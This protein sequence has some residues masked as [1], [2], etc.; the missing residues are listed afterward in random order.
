MGRVGAVLTPVQRMAKPGP[1]GEP[2]T[3]RLAPEGPHA[4]TER[5]SS[6]GVLLVRDRGGGQLFVVS[7]QDAPSGPQQRD[8]AAGFQGLGTLVD[9]HH[10]EVVVGQQ[11]EGA[12]GRSTWSKSE[13]S[14]STDSTGCVI[15]ATRAPASRLVHNRV[16]H[17]Y[18]VQHTRILE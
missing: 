12:V 4:G 7:S 6:R 17:Y 10:I 8:P 13:P 2:G 16:L 3:S 18:C 14:V 5:H 15:T 9:D 11:L 1:P